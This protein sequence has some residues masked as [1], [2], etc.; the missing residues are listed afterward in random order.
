MQVLAGQELRAAIEEAPERP[1][2]DSLD[3]AAENLEKGGLPR[4]FR[5]TLYS[6]TVLAVILSAIPLA[7]DLQRYRLATFIGYFGTSIPDAFRIPALRLGPDTVGVFGE[8]SQGDQLLLFGDFPKPGR[9]GEQFKALWDSDPA[10]PAYFAEYVRGLAWSG[11]TPLPVDYLATADRL[12]PENAWFRYF[13]AG[14]AARKAVQKNPA[15]PRTSPAGRIPAVMVKDPAKLAE[16]VT[17]L[18]EAA[19]QPRFK[20]YEG[21]LLAQRIHALPP[22]DDSLGRLFVENYLT[23]GPQPSRWI[24]KPIAE[25]VSVKCHELALAGDTQGFLKVSASWETFLRRAMENP[26]LPDDNRPLVAGLPEAAKE[27]MHSAKALGLTEKAAY[28]Q[29]LASRLQN[30]RNAASNRLSGAFDLRRHSGPDA[31]HLIFARAQLTHPPALTKDE[32]RPGFRANI[33]RREWLNSAVKGTMV[34]VAALYLAGVRFYRGPQVRV[35][36][37][38]LVRILQ[39]KDYA[40]ILIGGVVLPVL[41]LGLTEPLEPNSQ[42][43]FDWLLD[44]LRLA[45]QATLLLVI[46]IMI[47][48]RR[49][50]RRLG[51]LGWKVRGLSEPVAVSLG[52]IMVLVSRF[53]TPQLQNDFWFAASCCMLPFALI[54]P[55]LPLGASFCPR[56]T[57]VLWHTCCRAL[58]PAH[59]LSALLLFALVPCYRAVERHWTKLNVL[60]KIEPGVPALNRYEHQVQ[61][62]VRKNLLELLDAKP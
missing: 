22:G 10:N 37:L 21:E 7:R 17:W 46:P 52:V 11:S 15:G 51:P 6:L 5:A 1:G 38:S 25:T 40:W 45:L 9:P 35:L 61:E 29:R 4:W 47:S 24:Y 56:K 31:N 44:P 39:P 3:Q 8:F 53:A 41:V 57:A 14:V 54:Y 32:L 62:Q 43:G 23:K 20:S 13:A 19:R 28:Y 48:I 12:D 2:S 34:L 16:V 33:A 49:L 59:F 30:L 36:S 42:H 58:V 50:A 60:T 55:F 18:E 27:M 26:G